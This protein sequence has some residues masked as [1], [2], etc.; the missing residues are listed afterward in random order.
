[1][2]RVYCARPRCSRFLGRQEE[3]LAWLTTGTKAYTCTCGMA[4]CSRCKQAHENNAK[5]SC[6]TDDGTEVVLALGKVEGWARCPGCRTMIELNMGCFHMTCVCKTEFC[7]LCQARWKTC[8]CKQWDETRLVVAAE[9][10]IDLELELIEA[11]HR[12]AAVLARWNQIRAIPPRPILIQPNR[13]ELVQAA[14]DELRVY[15]DCRHTRWRYRDGGGIC[16]GCYDVL[17]RYVFH[18][19]GCHTVACNRCRLNRF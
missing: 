6:K 11:A 9:E 2:K 12:P 13:V 10:R 17:D 8:S 16:V 7:Y 14:V 4:T 19:V 1:V 15:H 5:H 18:C 3:G